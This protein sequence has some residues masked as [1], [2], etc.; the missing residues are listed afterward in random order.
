MSEH[1]TGDAAC[2]RLED[3]QA[4]ALG[5]GREGRAGRHRPEPLELLRPAGSRLIRTPVGDARV[6]DAARAGV[7]V[8]LLARPPAPRSSRRGARAA[9]RTSS[10]WFLC[11]RSAATHSDDPA[12]LQAEPRAHRRPP[13]RAGARTGRCRAERR[14][15]PRGSRPSVAQISSRA[16][17]VPGDQRV[18]VARGAATTWRMPHVVSAPK[19]CTFM[20]V[21]SWSVT[22]EA[23]PASRSGRC[24]PG[25]AA[26]RHRPG[27][28]CAGASTCSAN[29]RR[30]PAVL[31]RR[32]P[33][34]AIGRRKP[35]ASSARA[36]E[37][38]VS[39]IR[40]SCGYSSARA[41]PARAGRSPGRRSRRARG[42]ER[43]GRL[44]WTG[45]LTRHETSVRPP[46]GSWPTRCT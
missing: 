7:R 9:A 1:A 20:K 40:R 43:S 17:A 26:G 5:A 8:V 6:A 35:S 27:A 21:T 33:D 46:G 13:A 19:V 38:V 16:A 11:G 2:H 32:Q 36:P 29:W 34:D 39:T 10:S 18:R 24:W 31:L 37:P 12:V 25:C 28:P 23:S 41:W 14:R 42:T 3:G 15:T 4:E 30:E 22:T 45:A 44:L